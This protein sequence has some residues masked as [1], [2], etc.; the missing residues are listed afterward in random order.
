M[1][2]AKPLREVLRARTDRPGFTLVELLVVIAIIGILI[3]LLL[4]AI[5]AAREAAR[6]MQ[7]KNNLKQ[8]GLACQ[9][10][11]SAFRSFPTGGWGWNFVGDPD[12]GYGRKQPGSWAFV[13]LSFEEQKSVWA[14]GKGISLKTNPAGKKAAAWP[15]MHTPISIYYCPSRPRGGS[16]YPCQSNTYKN[17]PWAVNCGWTS[18]PSTTDPLTFVNKGDYAANCGAGKGQPD[19]V[20]GPGDYQSGDNGGYTNWP[21]AGVNNGVVFARSEVTIALVKDG[22]SKTMIIGEKFIP[23]DK[24][25]DGSDPSDNECVMTG[26]DNDNGRVAD[27]DDPPLQDIRTTD[28]SYQMLKT[29]GVQYGSAHAQGFNTL[30]CDASVHQVDYEVDMTVFQ[31]LC[32]KAD[33]QTLDLTNVH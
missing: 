21:A 8:M 3:A 12:R 19:Q 23:S 18:P 17:N 31:H 9:N 25:S 15:Q 26:Y 2:K 24:Y 22:T 16:L 10:H 32:N 27:P 11:L 6:R 5:Q 13:L 1:G 29:I 28:P 30:F 33:N 7:C 4:P 20:Q 14:A